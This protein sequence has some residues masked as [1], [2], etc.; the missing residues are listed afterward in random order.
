MKGRMSGRK[1]ASGLTMLFFAGGLT[2]T[3]QENP[4]LNPA[5]LNEQAPD[6]FAVRFE[7]TKGDFVVE[8]DREWAP[9]GVDRFYNLVQN[10]FYD[11]ARFFRVVKGFVVQFGLNG[12]PEV[13]AAWREATIED[14]PVKQGNRTGYL[15]Y[16]K[17]TQPNSRTTQVFINLVDNS[18]LDRDGFATFGKVTEGMDI[19]RSLHAG[20]GEGPPRGRG[21]SQ[22]RITA[23]GNA[24]LEKDF[25][26]L[27]YIK[28]ATVIP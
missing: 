11:G 10:G 23:E 12:D 17:S 22:A 3:A 21:P 8:V 13:T 24:Y 9:I 16:A 15:T 4:L 27:D 5:A 19:V 20:Y 25:P 14:D 1:L 26:E 7:T 28:G 6:K 18:R 2:S